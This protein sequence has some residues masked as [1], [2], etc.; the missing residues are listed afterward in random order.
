MRPSHIGQMSGIG[1]DRLGAG[2]SISNALLAAEQKR[3][4]VEIIPAIRLD[5]PWEA[6]ARQPGKGAANAKFGWRRPTPSHA[7]FS[8]RTAVG[9][10]KVLSLRRLIYNN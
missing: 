9:L 2:L 10:V 1:P 5:N 6:A 7:A 3:L 4:G 8:Y